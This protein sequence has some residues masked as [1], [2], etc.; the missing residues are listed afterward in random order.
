MARPSTN[1]ALGPPRDTKKIQSVQWSSKTGAA[2]DVPVQG[3]T[4]LGDPQWNLDK[5][6]ARTLQLYQLLGKSDPIENKCTSMPSELYSRADA[7][8]RES[9]WEVTPN[10]TRHP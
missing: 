8:V 10:D 9:V 7:H 1:M 5:K 4:R 2:T 3:G 6:Q